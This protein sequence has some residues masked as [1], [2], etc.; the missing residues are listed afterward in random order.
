VRVKFLNENK[1]L[2]TLSRIAAMLSGPGQFAENE[3]NEVNFREIP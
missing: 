1:K 3:A 2:L